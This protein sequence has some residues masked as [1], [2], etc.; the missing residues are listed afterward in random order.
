[1]SFADLNLLPQLLDAVRDAGYTEVPPGTMTAIA[2]L[3]R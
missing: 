2:W 1:M 3:V